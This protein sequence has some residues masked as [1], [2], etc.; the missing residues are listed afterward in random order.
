LLVLLNSFRA[1][2]VIW[3]KKGGEQ[4][5]TSVNKGFESNAKMAQFYISELLIDEQQHS[6]AEILNYVNQKSGGIGRKV[7]RLTDET[8]SS[9]LGSGILRN[10]ADY[11]KTS[12][13]WYQKNPPLY[14]LLAVDIAHKEAIY[15]LTE[16]ARCLRRIG[17]ADAEI[18]K[19]AA[20]YLIGENEGVQMLMIKHT[21]VKRFRS[22]LEDNELEEFDGKAEALDKALEGLRELV[23]D[24]NIPPD[25]REKFDK[26]EYIISGFYG[27]DFEQT[28]AMNM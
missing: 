26:S 2:D 18:C 4:K 22:K 19:D 24:E 1:E 5:M 3:L 27:K 17:H 23:A 21:N 9:T 6:K 13:G 25:I 8:I 15:F 11:T 12:K 20:S 14:D 10:N 7:K 28:Q 16:Q